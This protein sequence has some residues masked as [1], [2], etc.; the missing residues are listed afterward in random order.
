M[1]KLSL[2]IFILLLFS[3]SWNGMSQCTI[4]IPVEDVVIEGTNINPGDV[5]CLLAGNKDYLLFR[6]LQGTAAQPITIINKNGA[7]VINTNHVYGIKFDNCKHIIFSGTGASGIDYGFQIQRV[8]NDNGGAGMSVDNMSTNIEIEFIEVSNTSIGGIYAKTEPYQGDCDN[9]ITRDKFTMYD[10]KIHDC[11]IHDIADEGFYI[12]SS[13]Y[14]GQTI[15]ACDDVV[16]LP[17]VIEGVEI[18]NN[19]VENTGWDGIQVSSS[20][21][22]CNIYNNIIRYDS[23]E[24]YPYQ[25]SGILI[26]GGSIC[27]CYNN[28]IYDGKGDGI[29]ILGLGNMKIFNNLIVRAGRSYKPGNINDQKH[30]IWVGEVETLFGAEFEIYNNTIISPKSFGIK[31]TNQEAQMVYIK[32]NIITEPGQLPYS[33]DAYVHIDF[34]ISPSKVQASN[35]FIA[36]YNNTLKFLDFNN[37]DFDLKP[38]SPA[39]NIGTSLTYEGVTFDIEN[40][41]RPWH[42][43]FDAGAY[44]CHDPYA[45]IS[46]S[47][48]DFKPPFPIPAKDYIYLPIKTLLTDII[49]LNIV[50]LQG[51]TI[52]SK[53]YSTVSTKDNM[54]VIDVHNIQSG[55][56]ILNINTSNDITNLP[57]IIIK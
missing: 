52:L 6:D 46:E 43:Y 10:L 38:N 7:V 48:T 5:V 14:T 53:K 45:S 39:V 15:Y 25:M 49:T 1:K 20:P 23:Q 33:N 16:V 24:E 36:P 56:Y 28:Q 42:T 30:G 57:I 32:N 22:D 4:E 27:D 21:V 13:K 12:G 17:H 55:S 40:R 11:Y 54:I 9:L 47:S 8:E 44:E 2:V 37:N 29:D 26:G 35:N 41:S 34:N 3:F 51:N 19:I 31:Y 50:S 18:Y